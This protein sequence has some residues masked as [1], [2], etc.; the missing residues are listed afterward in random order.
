[1]VIVFSVCDEGVDVDMAAAPRVTAV[2]GERKVVRS[3]LYRPGRNSR[4]VGAK[5]Y[6]WLTLFAEGDDF[7][8]GAINRRRRPRELVALPPLAVMQGFQNRE[9]MK[10]YNK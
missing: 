2:A 7:Q 4:V 3:L 8:E 6:G 9:Q 10:G 5:S 1:M